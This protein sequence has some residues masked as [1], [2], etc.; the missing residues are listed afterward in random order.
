MYGDTTVIRALAHRLRE[1]GSE[2]RSEADALTGRAEAVPWDG[3]AAEAMRRL[4]RDQAGGLRT[5]AALHEEAAEALERHAREV[6]HLKDLI[7]AVERHVLRLMDGVG[8]VVYALASHVVPDAVDH[9]LAG[10]EPPPHG[11]RE[12]LDVDVPRPA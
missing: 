7:A 6:D 1:Q 9:W 12:W 2:I 3:L 8:G 10:F 4:A 5:C 11:S